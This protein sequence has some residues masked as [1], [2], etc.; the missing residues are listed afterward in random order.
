MRRW[1]TLELIWHSNKNIA[2]YLGPSGASRS[3]STTARMASN[4]W[5]SPSSSTHTYHH[6]SP[7]L[8][9]VFSCLLRRTVK[10]NVSTP[11]QDPCLV[12]GPFL[13]VDP[14]LLS[15]YRT[16]KSL[17]RSSHTS[18]YLFGTPPR[19]SKLGLLSSTQAQYGPLRSPPTTTASQL[20][21][22]MGKSSFGAFAISFLARTSL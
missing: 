21:R 14:P 3:V 4:C 18:H 15:F 9:M 6:R 22:K 2:C 19:T 16:T 20:A 12:H 1:R 17:L 11:L 13:V 10:S 5:T 7:G 8:V